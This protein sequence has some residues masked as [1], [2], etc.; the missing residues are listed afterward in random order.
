MYLIVQSESNSLLF[1]E[2]LKHSIASKLCLGLGLF[3]F[4]IYS[5]IILTTDYYNKNVQYNLNLHDWLIYT[6]DRLFLF[7]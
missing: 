1:F 2:C 6:F 4:L 3:S 7:K 5:L